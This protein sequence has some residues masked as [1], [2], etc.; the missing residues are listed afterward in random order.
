MRGALEHQETGYHEAMPEP[1][2]Q[3]LKKKQTLRDKKIN[4]RPDALLASGRASSESGA[5]A[6]SEQ[7]L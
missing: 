4:A 5:G 3:C 1:G 2:M 6:E 7:E